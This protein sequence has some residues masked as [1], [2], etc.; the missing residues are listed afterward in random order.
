MFQDKRGDYYD[1]DT[2]DDDGDDEDEDEGDYQDLGEDDDHGDDIMTARM[3]WAQ[4]LSLLREQMYR[5][6]LNSS[7]ALVVVWKVTHVVA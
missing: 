2:D 7:V 5:G 1:Y 6:W 4:P 3:F